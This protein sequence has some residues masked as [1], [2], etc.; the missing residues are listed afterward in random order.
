VILGGLADDRGLVRGE[1]QVLALLLNP[2]D[3]LG[4]VYRPR[5]TFGDFSDRSARRL[6]R[7]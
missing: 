3:L 4:A 1:L 6:A 2:G 5:V 7:S